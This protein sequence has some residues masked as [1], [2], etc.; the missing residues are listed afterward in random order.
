MTRVLCAL[1]ACFASAV[2]GCFSP[3]LEGFACGPAGDCPDGYEC[4]SDNQCVRPGGPQPGI[5]AGP[6]DPSDREAPRASVM[7]PLPA[8]MT[9]ASTITVR[10]TATDASPIV[11]VTVNGA[12]AASENGFRDWTA[13][14]PLSPGMNVISVDTLDAQ[15]NQ[16]VAA[17]S[18]T[19]ERV[20]RLLSDPN[21]AAVTP[22]GATVLVFDQAGQALLGIDVAT[23]E[24]RVISDSETGSGPALVDVVALAMTP[25]GAQVLA[26]DVVEAALVS[27]DLATGDRLTISGDDVGSGERFNSLVGLTV[28]PTGQ[29]AFLGDDVEDVVFAVDLATGARTVMSGTNAGGTTIGT[30]P[31]FDEI[32]AIAF[33]PAN[34]GVLV[35]DAGLQAL[36][37]IDLNGDRY[38]LADD[39][40]GSGPNLVE[41]VGVAPAAQGNLTFVVDKGLNALLRFNED[42]GNRFAVSGAGAGSGVRL[43]D[44]EALAIAPDFSRAF[45]VDDDY[46]V[47]LVIDLASGA[48]TPMAALAVGSGAELA[49]PTGVALDAARER[50]VVGDD[51]LN[52]LVVIDL[53]TGD[54][55]LL[56]EDENLLLRDP[57]VV[58]LHSDGRAVVMNSTENMCMSVDLA[59]GARALISTNADH[60]GPAW[61]GPEAMVLDATGTAALVADFTPM[62][63]SVDLATGER[64]LISDNNSAPGIELDAPVALILDDARNRVVIVDADA[65][66]LIAVDLA[67]GARS[68]LAGAGADIDSPAGITRGATPDSAVV[69]DEETDASE[70]VLVD[71]VTGD[72]ASLFATDFRDGMPLSTPE[73]MV[74]DGARNVLFV[75][76]YDLAGVVAIDMITG[77]RLIV[78]R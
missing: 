74:V 42:N 31:T 30:G 73:N 65:N 27:I 21:G 15:G 28:D 26:A 52:G 64:V 66:A 41:P 12:V 63:V 33:D 43:S 17:A 76:D 39:A 60:P 29:T 62:L 25:D 1:T 59:T 3:A 13:D 18:V 9:E 7:F 45:V 32:K 48:R 72:R 19:V 57:Q 14:V 23:G 58:A 36:F 38:I 8:G 77:A 50:L 47:P 20:S 34:N 49:N 51:A 46:V 40:L 53:A 56:P 71:L 5:D 6:P 69:Y 10:G 67:T 75:G 61:D 54:R 70:Y 24:R 11:A 44:I 78:S 68:E 55:T 16:E 22:D 35:V 4:S 2:A 37:G